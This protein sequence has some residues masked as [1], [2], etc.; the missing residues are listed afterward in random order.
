[1]ICRRIMT[2]QDGIL[3]IFGIYTGVGCRDVGMTSWTWVF[4]PFF[5]LDIFFLM[6]RGSCGYPRRAK[7]G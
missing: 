1:M 3:C 6:C 5:S 4:F 2:G 7:R